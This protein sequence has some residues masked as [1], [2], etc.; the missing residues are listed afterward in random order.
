VTPD[1][2]LALLKH[3]LSHA[4]A[5]RGA[6]LLHTRDLEL[7]MRRHGGP[8]PDAAMLDA[9]AKARR[10]PPPDAWLG[11][12]GET[13]LAAHA[14]GAVPLPDRVAEL[15][16]QA[17]AIV[18]GSQS[19]D[20]TALWAENA[21]QDAAA[22][23]ADLGEHAE[24]G[25][26]LTARDFS[27][28]L[29]GLLKAG[30]VRD[31]DKPHD[32]VMIWGTLEARVQGAD[33]LI[34]GGLNEGSWP[35]AARP[36]PWL[37][38]PM[39]RDAGLLLPER[40]IGLAAHDFQQ[41]AGAPEV[42]LCRS[43][44]SEDAETV[45]S[46]W[47]NRL[48]NLLGGLPACHGPEALEE[49][50]ARGRI[51]LDR[52]AVLDRAER[53]A[54]APRPSPRP[55]L[56]ARPRKLSVTRIRTL[57]RDPYAIYAEF[58]LRLRPLNPLIPEAD[59]ML[60]GTVLHRVFEEFVR[61]VVSDSGKLT[62]SALMSAADRV[63]A[64]DVP[65]AAER[66]FWRARVARIADWFVD[67]ERGRQD[68]A[69]PA[70]LEVDGEVDMV[71]PAF[72]LTAQAD[73]IDRGPSGWILYDYKTGTPPSAAEQKAFDKQLL[74][75]AA[76]LTMGGF[77]GLAASS[78]DR[79]TYIGLSGKGSVVDAPLDMGTS[80]IW[81]EFRTLIR[82]F[83]DPGQGYTARRLMRMDRQA[84]DYDQLA[85]FGEWDAA[86]DPTPEDIT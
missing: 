36:D 26:A 81:E 34:L 80:Q 30:E 12:V 2:L 45:P 48:T 37:S 66:R 70:A 56:A 9:F 75:E 14:P 23:L 73:R 20:D 25:G 52:A 62:T 53:C 32:L 50:R 8:R 35:E 16:S 41:A 64:Q 31:R 86:T 78:V 18:A 29:T 63:L 54:P 43:K 46:R 68:T 76:M 44:R 47:L 85:R 79:A 84:G 71:D 17:G 51:W 58:I 38:R 5:G 28:L 24:A 67:G 15:L 4:G 55:P 83:D 57:I 77:R 69:H 3:P 10:T 72:V 1:A 7:W 6:H 13:V 65:W 74:L 49:M 19:T 39:R 27:A 59:A 60:R 22:T 82:A 11:W 40:R 42:W 33:L 21:G 61:E